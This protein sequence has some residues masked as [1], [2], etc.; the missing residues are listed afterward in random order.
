MSCADWVN[1]NTERGNTLKF[2]RVI[3]EQY[4]SRKK[5]IHII[6]NKILKKWICNL[7]VTSY[8]LKT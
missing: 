5:H 3:L 4:L 8:E 1:G 7:R 2:L 6:E